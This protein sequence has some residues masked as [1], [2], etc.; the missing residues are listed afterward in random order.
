MASRKLTKAS[1]LG[2]SAVSAV[3]ELG[4]DA[5]EPR[6]STGLDQHQV[7]LAERSDRGHRIL[8]RAHAVEIRADGDEWMPSASA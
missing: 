1:I 8:G 3:D 4:H 2:Q 5:F 7:A 6:R